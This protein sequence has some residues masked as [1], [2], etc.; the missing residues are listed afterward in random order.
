MTIYAQDYLWQTPVF[1]LQWL[2]SPYIK[3]S[4]LTE[5]ANS[6]ELLSWPSLQVVSWTSGRIL[7]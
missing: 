7:T 3:P 6:G 1:P 5:A 2:F 4:C